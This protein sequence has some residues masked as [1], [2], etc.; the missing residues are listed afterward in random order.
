[1]PDIDTMKT[2]KYLKKEDVGQ[3][4]FATIT[5]VERV[6]PSQ[7]SNSTDPIWLIHFSELSKPLWSKPTTREQIA[8]CLNQRNSDYW[9]GGQ[10]QLWSDPSVTNRGAIVGGIRVRPAQ[11]QG[12]QQNYQQQNYQQQN[13]QQNQNQPPSPPEFDDDIPGFD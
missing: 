4:V 2:S 12:Q 11:Q 9:V 8:Q 7:E 6:E 5:K 3:G 1:M 10:I 13:Y